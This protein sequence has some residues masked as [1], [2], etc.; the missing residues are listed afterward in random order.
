MIGICAVM[1]AVFLYLMYNAETLFWVV[2]FQC[3]VYSVSYTHLKLKSG[4]KLLG[5][6]LLAS[7]VGFASFPAVSAEDAAPADGNGPMCIRD[8]YR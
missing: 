3:G 8:S 1:T 2:V 4:K 7:L 6:L 5:A